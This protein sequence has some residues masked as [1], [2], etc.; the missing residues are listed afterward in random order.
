VDIDETSTPKP[1]L[2][3]SCNHNFFGEAKNLSKNMYGSQGDHR[4]PPPFATHKGEYL[5][6]IHSLSFGSSLT[7]KWSRIQYAGFPYLEELMVN[8]YRKFTVT[9]NIVMFCSKML[10]YFGCG[11]LSV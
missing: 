11:S 7:L 9:I 5:N 10:Y 6:E 8:Y 4:C 1:K 2:T 3:Y